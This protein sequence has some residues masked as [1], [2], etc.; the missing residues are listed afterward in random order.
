M[1]NRR[2]PKNSKIISLFVT[3]AVLFIIVFALGVIIGKGLGSS[4]S[5]TVDRD[6]D[7]EAPEIEYGGPD[8]E[9]EESEVSEFDSEEIIL[10]DEPA[11]DQDAQEE[12]DST[13]KT[14][15][16]EEKSAEAATPEK[17]PEEVK[18]P[19]KATPQPKQVIEEKETADTIVEK[20]APPEIK[21][22]S[23][24]MPKIDPD[25]RYTVQIGAFQNQTEANKLVNSLKSNG[26]PAFIKQVQT[27]DNKNW[28]RV[29]VGTFSNRSD[30]VSYGDK[31]KQRASGV[32][33][34]FIT[35][36]N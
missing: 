8:M 17:A 23:G 4:E 6:Y 1:S 26:Y 31:L 12:S 2:N 11:A 19:E 5:N 28:Y 25:G 7:I 29:R 16:Q 13:D 35:I 27:P 34:V 36:N 33:S 30:A 14:G 20:P 21:S 15:S 18:A 3:F 24:A 9:P 22:G 10:D 32:K